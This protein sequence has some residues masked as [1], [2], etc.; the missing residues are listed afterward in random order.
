MREAEAIPAPDSF[1]QIDTLDFLSRCCHSL[2]EYQV[3]LARLAR[4]TW[5][6]IASRLNVTPEVARWTL[7]CLRTRYQERL[8]R[9]NASR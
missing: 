6:E 9:L 3:L 2:I 7:R 1:S 4:Y 8:G 5:R